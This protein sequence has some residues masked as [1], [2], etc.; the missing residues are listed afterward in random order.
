[1]HGLRLEIS[2][3]RFDSMRWRELYRI[4]SARQDGSAPT[5]PIM[6]LP[7][8]DHRSAAMLIAPSLIR[9]APAA[10]PPPITVGMPH[11]GTP[12]ARSPTG[13][14]N[15]NVPTSCEPPDD[16]VKPGCST[17]SE[18]AGGSKRAR[19]SRC[20]SKQVPVG[21]MGAVALLVAA[22]VAQHAT[23]G[24]F[25]PTF[26]VRLMRW[27]DFNCSASSWIA[28]SCARRM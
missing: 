11:D 15:L 28:G 26:P 16:G 8:E 7:Q 23:S 12:S 3:A 2:E 18:S 14:T 21:A 6:H 17:E 24:G 25:H 4:A 1:V 27:P 22:A 13:P 20:A 5:S 19:A 9:P 10:P